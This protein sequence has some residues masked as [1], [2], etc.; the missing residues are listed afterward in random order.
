MILFTGCWMSAI[1]AVGPLEII[2][3]TFIQCLRKLK[4]NIYLHRGI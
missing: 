3:I 2:L 1:K 4:I